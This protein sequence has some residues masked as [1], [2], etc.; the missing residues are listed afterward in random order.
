M[1]GFHTE[2][3]F[4]KKPLY[5][6]WGKRAPKNWGSKRPPTKNGGVKKSVSQR[7]P[8]FLY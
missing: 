8:N 5:L 3:L 2:A 1:G 4:G 6:S 7:A